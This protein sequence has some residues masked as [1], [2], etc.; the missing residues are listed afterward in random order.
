MEWIPSSAYPTHIR[1]RSL[2]PNHPPSS[3]TTTPIT[4]ISPQTTASMS[5]PTERLPSLIPMSWPF[6]PPHELE[7]SH[8]L[9]NHVPREREREQ[10]STAQRLWDAEWEDFDREYMQNRERSRGREERN[11]H[12]FAEPVLTQG[13]QRPR[14]REQ[15]SKS[16]AQRLW[17]AEWEDV[18]LQYLQDRETRRRTEQNRQHDIAPPVPSQHYQRQHD[19]GHHNPPPPADP[20]DGP[21]GGRERWIYLGRSYARDSLNGEWK[22][23]PK[24]TVH[25]ETDLYGFPPGDPFYR[26]HLRYTPRQGDS[27]DAQGGQAAMPPMENGPPQM[28]PPQ[29]GNGYGGG[30]AQPINH[31]S[32]HQSMPR[33]PSPPPVPHRPRDMYRDLGPVGHGYPGSS[34]SVQQDR[35]YDPMRPA[36]PNDMRGSTGHGQPLSPGGAQQKNQVPATSEAP[37]G[38]LETRED[39]WEFLFGSKGYATVTPGD[40]PPFWWNWKD[41]IQ[42][43]LDATVRPALRVELLAGC[44]IG[45]STK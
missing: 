16:V 45:G 37:P 4:Q 12:N 9:Y 43:G 7:P 13:H 31:G 32:S 5:E 10:R 44:G 35:Y 42:R 26:P 21:R 38:R 1:S 19:Q 30:H 15:Q 2:P 28:P 41:Y 18:D 14:D 39:P 29:A 36:Q 8:P 3:P 20:H 27:G 23:V 11:Q 6:R 34:Q 17:D 22:Q 33:P 25:Q 24:P 40:E